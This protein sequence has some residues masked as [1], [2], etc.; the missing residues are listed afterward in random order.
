MKLR[1]GLVRTLAAVIATTL[2]G[3][4]ALADSGASYWQGVRSAGVLK[5]GAASAPPFLIR[6]P[7]TGNYT[8]YFADLCR[9]FGDVLGVKTEFV[10]TTWDNMVAGVQA[11][12]WDLAPALDRTPERAI[13]INFSAPVSEATYTFA[14]NKENPKVPADPKSVA[15]IDKAGVTVAVIAGSAQD[16]AIAAVLHQATVLRLPTNEEVNLAV[17]T[18]RADV[19]GNETAMN[20]LFVKANPTWATAFSPDPA[21][22]HR[23]VGFGLPR[24]LSAADVAVLDIFI[25]DAKATGEVDRLLNKAIDE[26][27]AASK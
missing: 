24:S 1:I 2:M 3:G 19:V 25:Q 9:E 8:G 20:L 23:G 10:D 21:I 16:K 12:K 26:V 17:K 18:K 4:A 14:Y 13:A 15:D 6:D 7:A 22:V 11:G 5:C 27:L